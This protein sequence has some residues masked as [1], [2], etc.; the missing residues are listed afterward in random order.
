VEL[1]IE[2]KEKEV[3]KRRAGR[4]ANFINLDGKTNNREY[5]ANLF[6][7]IKEN[8]DEVKRMINEHDNKTNLLKL[9]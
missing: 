9:L 6:R 7:L 3:R 8:M 1:D 5:L 2:N 4:R